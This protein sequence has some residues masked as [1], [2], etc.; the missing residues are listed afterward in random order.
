MNVTFTA[1][2]GKP[3]ASVASPPATL[4][5]HPPAYIPAVA[6]IP[7]GGKGEVCPGFKFPSGLRTIGLAG[8]VSILF[9]TNVNNVGL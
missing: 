1:G 2:D 8:G 3:D 6:T 9:D 7:V 5:R 4:L